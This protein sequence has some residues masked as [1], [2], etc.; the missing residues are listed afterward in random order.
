MSCSRVRRELSEYLDDELSGPQLHAVSAHLDSC[1][2]CARHLEELRSA[3]ESLAGLPRLQ[4]P[5]PMAAGV[6][7]RVEVE[8]RGPGLALLFRSALA[9]RPLMFPSILPA[10]LVLMCT[11]SGVL[12]IG[13]RDVRSYN[14]ANSAASDT[15]PVSPGGAVS[16][17]QTTASDIFVD[18][19]LA[20]LPHKSESLFVETVVGPDGSV[21]NVTLLEGDSNRAA[22]ILKALRY[23]RY[24]PGLSEQGEPVKMRAYRLID[25]VEV[26]A[27]LT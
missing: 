9:A 10:A 19:Q 13:A 18:Y 3:C 7:D 17:P 20:L 15:D 12:M 2:A 6:L 26:R 22:P 5:E 16:A 21:L 27:P 14:Y 11:G 1:A 4:A 8:S 24:M 25:S 23:Q